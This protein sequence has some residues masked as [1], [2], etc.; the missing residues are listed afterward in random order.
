[1]GNI[2]DLETMQGTAV[3]FTATA[4]DSDIPANTLSLPGR[5]IPSGANRL[6]RKLV[7]FSGGQNAS[8]TLPGHTKL[9]QVM[10]GQGGSDT[11]VVS[12]NVTNC[13]L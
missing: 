3:S 10:D 2:S 8:I 7:N 12:I 11:Q 9:S 1:M 4:T 5:Q 13:P 6:I